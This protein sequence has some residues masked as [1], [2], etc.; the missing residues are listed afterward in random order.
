MS[1]AQPITCPGCGLRVSVD[2]A[3]PYDGYFNTSPECWSLFTEVIGREFGNSVLFG[4]V[5][6]LTVDAYAV[7]HAGGEH[8]DKSVDIHLIGLYLALECAVPLARIAPLFQRLANRINY[9][10]HLPPPRFRGRM[11]IRDVADTQSVNE[12]IEAVNAWARSVW[13]AWSSCQDKIAGFVRENL[14]IG[15]NT[16]PT[17]FRS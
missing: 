13:S 11:T 5:H 17:S 2:G 3:P 16:K 10:P 9:W 8:P 6:R 12:H 15:R 1:D 4:A 14:N 7:Q